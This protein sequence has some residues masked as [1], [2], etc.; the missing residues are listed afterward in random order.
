MEDSTTNNEMSAPTPWRV[1]AVSGLTIF[2]ADDNPIAH[3]ISSPNGLEVAKRIV[4]CVN[5]VAEM[6]TMSEQIW[7]RINAAREWGSE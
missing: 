7:K 2:D 5:E 3:V 1:S 6:E 4:K